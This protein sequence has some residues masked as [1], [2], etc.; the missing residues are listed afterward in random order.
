MNR[1]ENIILE[2]L[3][4]GAIASRPA[5][6]EQK[7]KLKQDFKYGVEAYKFVDIHGRKKYT[8]YTV[9][10]IS[11]FMPDDTKYYKYENGEYIFVI[12]EKSV[13]ETRETIWDVYIVDKK[14]TFPKIKDDVIVDNSLGMYKKSNIITLTQYNRLMS[15]QR[16]VPEPES[17]PGPK[18][19][20]D[21]DTVWIDKTQDYNYIPALKKNI[22]LIYNDIWWVKDKAPAGPDTPWYDEANSENNGYFV[23]PY[24]KMIRRWK[25][26]YES[27]AV[28][29]E[30][31][32]Y[33][34]I[35]NTWPNYGK[36]VEKIQGSAARASFDKIA[37]EIIGSNLT[38]TETKADFRD[39]LNIIVWNLRYF[40][41]DD[42][43]GIQSQYITLPVMLNNRKN[44]N[45]VNV[46]YALQMTIRTWLAPVLGNF[47]EIKNFMKVPIT[48][49]GT[50]GSET[51]AVVQKFNEKWTNGSD[52]SNIPSEKFLNIL[53]RIYDQTRKLDLQ[54]DG[55]I[56]TETESLKNGSQNAKDFQELLY[57]VGLKI[58][59]DY[60]AFKTFAKYRTEGPDGGWGGVIGDITLGAL[61]QLKDS[62]GQRLTVKWNNG[63]KDGVIE[64]LRK[65]LGTVSESINYFKGIGL[66]IKFRDLINEQ[67]T[68]AEEEVYGGTSTNVS[69][70]SKESSNDEP[71][72]KKPSVKDKPKPAIKKP[73][74]NDDKITDTIIRQE[75]GFL[76]TTNLYKRMKK[77]GTKNFPANSS[78]VASELKKLLY[79]K[80]I[81]VRSGI[82]KYRDNDWRG[83]NDVSRDWLTGFDGKISGGVANRNWSNT[84]YKNIKS[85]TKI[86]AKILDVKYI[87]G[88]YWAQP[89][90]RIWTYVYA[91]S[92]N[93]ATFWVPTTWI[94]I[95]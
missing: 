20:N 16:A 87:M 70:K 84:H 50:Y 24:Q 4:K 28:A 30:N 8:P 88:G 69:T 63:D 6:S 15:L 39:S 71:T 58:T 62:D 66:N 1:F 54:S 29:A 40:R 85:G 73:S 10:E 57:Q 36:S 43:E 64:E 52:T 12:D 65:T 41:L 13:R 26:G 83:Y 75:N 95:P 35:L 53:F 67:V 78:G 37:A 79:N 23:V 61:H 27:D 19:I 18:D 92:G 25:T 76:T 90:P 86:D 22:D 11:E 80:N 77:G 31:S 3:K 7:S 55:S 34:F 46:I 72:D 81:I 42:E 74:N 56:S 51:Q 38:K 14:K 33:A 49:Y 93:G 89:E 47:A 45:N 82:G 91:K 44:I 32:P 59:P 9:Q 2:R 68:A 5:D 60:T 21:N 17:Q 48:D 94:K